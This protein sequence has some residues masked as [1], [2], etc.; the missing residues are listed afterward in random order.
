MAKLVVSLY[1]TLCINNMEFVE[2]E[3]TN[4]N[5]WDDLNRLKNRIKKIDNFKFY[6]SDFFLKRRKVSQFE[7]RESHCETRVL[8]PQT[9]LAN[10]VFPVFSK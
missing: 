7:Y 6:L 1:K 9:S 4:E 10:R 5:G 2:R 3:N 8:V